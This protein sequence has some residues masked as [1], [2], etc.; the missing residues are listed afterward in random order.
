MVRHLLY[1]AF[2]WPY[3]EALGRSR[4][5]RLCEIGAKAAKEMAYHVRHAAEWVIRLGDGTQESHARAAAALDEMWDYTGELFDMDAAERQLVAAAIAVDRPALRPAFDATIDAVLAEA[6]LSRTAERW[7]Q[8]G[9]RTG[10]HSEHLGHLLAEMQ[11]LNPAHR[12]AT[13]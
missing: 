2:M 12:G 7:M 10:R 3:F 6:T 9:G 1:A 11:V 5:R 8:R 13:W 4:D